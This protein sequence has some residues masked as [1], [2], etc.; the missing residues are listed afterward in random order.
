MSEA[1]ENSNTQSNERLPDTGE[2]Q[3]GLSDTVQDAIQ[4]RAQGSLRVSGL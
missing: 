4:L 3:L 1:A 2:A